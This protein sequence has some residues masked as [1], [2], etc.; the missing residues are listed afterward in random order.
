MNDD[1][2]AGKE[3]A[4]RATENDKDFIK[5]GLGVDAGG[6]YTDAVIYDLE[7][8]SALCKSKS[9]TTKWDFT[10]GISR[11]LKKLDQTL[12]QKI[13]LISLSTTLAT[14]A[15]VENEGQK[16]GLLL[17]P[18][19]GMDIMQSIPHQPKTVIQGQMEISGK[20]IVPVDPDEIRSTVSQ[21][22]KNHFVTAFAVSGFA[23]V[24]NPDQELQAK[25]IIQEETGCFVSCGHELSD[26]LNY[27][28]RA[29][30]AM[31]NAK[32]IPRLASLLLD[33]EKVMAGYGIKAPVVVMKGDGTL[34]SSEMAKKRPVETILSGPAASVAGA[35]HLT[36]FDDALV[37]DMGG[38]TIDT[39]ALSSGLVRLNKNGSTV[40]GHKT[41]VKALDI[42]TTGL[43]G[44]SLILYERRQ[45]I[46]G[47][48]RVAP[49]AWLGETMP[50]TKTAMAYISRHLQHHSASTREMQIL[51]KT[52][53]V[54]SLNLTPLEEKIITL[55][56]QRPYSIHEMVKAAGVP[57]ESS[58]NLERLEENFIIQKCGLTFTDL[59]HINGKFS[60]WDTKT[61]D[62]YARFYSH[63]AKL[64]L[65][66]MSA[67][68]FNLGIKQLSMELLKHRLNDDADSE[69][70]DECSLCKTLVSHLLDE[71]HPNY[72]IA[73][74]FTH[75]VVG[76]GAPIRFF[77]PQ[78]VAPFNTQAVIPEDADV[79]NAIGAITSHVFIKK[80]LRIVP[81]EDNRFYIEGIPGQNY[82]D[83]LEKA[84]KFAR[85]ILTQ[86]VQ[87]KAEEA[88][89]SCKEINLKV[90]DMIPVTPMGEEVFMERRLDA[91]L[92]GR[93]DLMVK[94]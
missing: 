46:L 23:S 53:K 29:A 82:F 31:L 50:G 78:A 9:L 5:I 36:G 38:T 40:G 51:A 30:T 22:V 91:T 84:D 92:K 28:T 93:P 56:E 34:M 4:T 49:V 14:N 81:T 60:Q 66:E 13:E 37:M 72:E 61:A 62:Q 73:I 18:P 19:Y 3:N 11:A 15:I 26:N 39:A 88:G 75:P 64:P 44:D 48:K 87:A 89:T 80:Q 63:L 41:H 16:V 8:N 58:L 79:A 52:G 1:R 55:L 71:Q 67:R 45:F 43:G 90:K 74:N 86:M 25:K 65:P 35:R 20:E 76:I 83:A 32:I 47:P 94:Q 2:P 17:M 6:T 21:M 85:Q 12:L 7:N 10:L 24:A 27:Q 70:L 69:K 59:L 68:I 54:K 33:L 57:Y 77:L 42:R